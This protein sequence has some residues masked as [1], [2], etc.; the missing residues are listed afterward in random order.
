MDGVRAYEVF[1]DNIE[2][3]CLLQ[4]SHI[5]G[6]MLDEI[7]SLIQETVCHRGK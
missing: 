2:Y 6:F 4:D 5:D 1:E 3:D 7:V